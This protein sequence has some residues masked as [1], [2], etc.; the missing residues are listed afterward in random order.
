MRASLVGLL[1]AGG[2]LVHGSGRADWNPEPSAGGLAVN[3]GLGDQTYPAMVSNGYG[4][5]FMSWVDEGAGGEVVVQQIHRNGYS[6]WTAG[7]VVVTT[8]AYATQSAVVPDGTGG[9][10][11]IW[12]DHRGTGGTVIYG[13]RVNAAGVPQWGAGGV[14]L[15]NAGTTINQIIRYRLGAIPDGGGGAIMCW[16]QNT[17]NRFGVE[18]PTFVRA[19]RVDGNGVPLWGTAGIAFSTFTEGQEYPSLCSDAAGG[20]IVTWNEYRSGSLAVYAQRANSAGVVQ[21]TA[22]GVFQASN[23]WDP[24]ITP[25]GSGGAIIAFQS[26]A[27]DIWARRINSSGGTVWF[28]TLVCDATGPQSDPVVV[29]D[30]AGDVVIA[31]IDYRFAPGGVFCQRFNA[32]GAAQWTANGIQAGYVQG[33]F[34]EGISIASDGAAGAVLAWSDLNIHAHHVVSNGTF[35]PSSQAD[36]CTA[37]DTQ[38]MHCIVPVV[39][40]SAIIAWRDYRAG[41]SDI[42]AQRLD[43]YGYLGDPMPLITSVEDV[44]NDQGGQVKVSWSASRIDDEFAPSTFLYRVWRKSL[45]GPWTIMGSQSYGPLE[46]YSM[47]VPTE[48]DSSYFTSFMVEARLSANA[49]A[50]N[51]FA[52]SDSGY[53]VD[54]TTPLA[55]MALSGS[56]VEGT[57]RLAWSPGQETDLVGYRVYR[58]NSANFATNPETFVGQ[59]S[60]SN[61]EDA[62]GAWFAYRVTSIDRNGNESAS[63]FWAPTG[64]DPESTPVLR[65]HAPQ[66]NPALRSTALAFS[67]PRSGSASVVICDVAGRQVRKFLPGSLQAGTHRIDWDLRDEAGSRVAPGIYF[68]RLETEGDPFLTRSLVVVR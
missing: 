57:T 9:L 2:M 50:P 67:L 23:M 25:D 31:W 1:V 52:F 66:P 8:G 26:V 43:T 36:I 42:Y 65:L 37:V 63:A 17:I 35:W 18:G 20:V 12:L 3:T 54:N 34:V 11:V 62:A 44:P 49:G 51:W 28:T 40:G 46:N 21:W 48:A 56:Y 41:N 30:G 7:G 5:A 4:G 10:V 33:G 39:G 19:Q 45:A 55:P 13:Q 53:S 64:L 22:N 60:L 68:V 27:F 16:Q 38:N 47:V 15:S 58:G 61:Y 59:T 6:I 14:A 24:V 29:G 32:S